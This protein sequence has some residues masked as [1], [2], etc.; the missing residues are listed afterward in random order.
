VLERVRLGRRETDQ[1]FA[2]YELSDHVSDAR[3]V[4][5]PICLI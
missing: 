5:V 3:G 1:V 4:S 2:S